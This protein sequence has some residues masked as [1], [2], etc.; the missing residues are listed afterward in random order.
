[1]KKPK[2]GNLVEDKVTGLRGIA[3]SK[4]KYLNGCVQIGVKPRA[5]KANK[6]P[7]TEYIDIEQVK[8]VGKGISIAKKDTGGPQRDAP[9]R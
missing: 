7:D 4:I 3:V 6:A 5:D 9:K 2:L 8:V 1:M